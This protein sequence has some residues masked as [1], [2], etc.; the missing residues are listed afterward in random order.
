MREVYEL[1]REMTIDA[2]LE[3]ALDFW[4]KKPK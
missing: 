1:T 2:S 4:L 3:T